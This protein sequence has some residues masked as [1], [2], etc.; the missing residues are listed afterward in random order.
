MINS[1]S[2]ID[3]VQ[4]LNH[5]VGCHGSSTYIYGDAIALW[6][7]GGSPTIKNS[8]FKN[9]YCGIYIQSGSPTLENLTFGENEEKNNID[10]YPIP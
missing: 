10:I 7:E 2:T 4:F 6:I 8:T 1:S 9:N 5:Q 3:N